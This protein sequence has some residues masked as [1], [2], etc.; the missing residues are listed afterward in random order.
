LLLVLFLFA[1]LVHLLLLLLLLLLLGAVPQL[2]FILIGVS[3]QLRGGGRT[4]CS[5]GPG[6]E[7]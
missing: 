1:A 7:A 2:A 6:Q 5:G 4:C 3:G